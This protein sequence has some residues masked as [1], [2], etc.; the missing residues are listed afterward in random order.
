MND[1]R[2]VGYETWG[3][4]CALCRTVV[5]L[6]VHHISS[7]R[8][9]SRPENLMPLCGTCHNLVT[10]GTVYID[11]QS[12]S[13]SVT[14]SGT[15]VRGPQANVPPI[16]VE[17]QIAALKQLIPDIWEMTDHRSLLLLQDGVSGAFYTECHV[18]ASSLVDRMDFD[19][20]N[21]LDTRNAVAYS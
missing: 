19:G 18:P 17:V 14:I 8:S 7:D 16:S 11:P 6:E 20:N 5:G 4:Q 15:F 9:D 12:R 21:I 13:A 3:R 1:Y 2:T 10:Q